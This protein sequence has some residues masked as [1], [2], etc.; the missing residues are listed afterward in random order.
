MSRVRQWR[1]LPAA[2]LVL[3]TASCGYNDEVN[4]RVARFDLAVERSRDEMILTNI[5]RASRAE[6]LAFIQLGKITGVN[7]FNSQLGL[8]SVVLGEPATT[9]ATRA[10]QSQYVFG[11][12]AAATGAS[13]NYLQYGGSTTFDASPSETKEFYLGLLAN[14]QPET[15][16]FFAQ[17]G[18]AR[19][20]LF[21]LFTDRVIEDKGGVITE[22]RN[23][24][25]EP[26]YDRFRRYVY[27]A[28]Q[29]GL[30]SEPQPDPISTLIRYGNKAAKP[31]QPAS[32]PP[33]NQTAKSTE[34]RLCFEPSA[35]APGMPDAHN[36]PLCGSHTKSTNPS[37]VSFTDAEGALVKVAI[38]PRST[39]SIFQFLGHI[40]ASGKPDAVKLT[41][42]DAI[43][44]APLKDDNLFMVTDK[45]SNECFLHV[46]YDFHGYC[47]PEGASNTKRI[48]GMLAQLIALNTS[49]RDIPI[50]PE[51]RLI[52]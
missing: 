46:N 1:A 42:A 8:P 25:L 21:N 34:Y 16:A 41:S 18:I 7:T 6:P 37:I 22:I 33:A 5:I 9:A 10:L 31:S 40:L 23:D 28:V 11:A 4:D 12:N 52:Q 30:S 3:L 38:L 2:L 49:I 20:T 17:Q 14:V 35:R 24:P 32:A 19:E 50:T 51:V 27:L 15:L 43:G 29:Y 39:F 36:A 45:P 48:I 44:R 26:G 47:V 13:S